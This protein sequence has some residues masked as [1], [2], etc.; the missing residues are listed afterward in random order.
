[1][2]HSSPSYPWAAVPSLCQWWRRARQ[3]ALAAAIDLREVDRLL[4][5]LYG[6]TVLDRSLAREPAEPIDWERLDAIWQQ[7]WR[8]RVP[9]QYLVGRVSWRQLELQVSPAVLIPR[10]ETELLVEIA[11][12]WVRSQARPGAWADLGTG[13]GAIAI[14]LA[15]ECPQ[16]EVHAV[17]ASAAALGVALANI[18]RYNLTRRVHVYEGSW[19]QPLPHLRGQ[20][21]GI[22][23]NPPYIPTA[24]IATLDAEVRQHEP[25][26]A[27]DGGATGLDALAKLVLEGADYLRPGGWW[28]VEVMQGQAP[29]VAQMLDSTGRYGSIGTHRDLSGIERAVSARVQ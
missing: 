20:L 15:V 7:R 1:M 28:L 9:L 6:W 13:S 23:S 14:G 22:V 16:L 25:R 8:D 24:T 21:Q 2:L 18:E 26:L 19:F 27:L 17:D 12:E 29:F 5:W 10:P 11:S 4:E 3:Q